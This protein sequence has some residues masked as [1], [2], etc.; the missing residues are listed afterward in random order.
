MA[1]HVLH[2]AGQNAQHAD[3]MDKKWREEHAESFIYM[4]HTH[5]HVPR[6][7]SAL[8]CSR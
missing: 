4:H 3:F 2:I 7:P 6:A 1:I 8:V 5:T